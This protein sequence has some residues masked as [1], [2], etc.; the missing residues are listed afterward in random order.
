M[1]WRRMACVSLVAGVAMAAALTL[2]DELL[3]ERVS[4]LAFQA[5]RFVVLLVVLLVAVGASGA[6][7]R[8]ERG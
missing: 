6:G 1:N 8:E 3:R 2:L 5:I 4:D 7:R